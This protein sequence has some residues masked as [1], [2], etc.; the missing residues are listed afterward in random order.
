MKVKYLKEHELGETLI[1]GQSASA[2]GHMRN[3]YYQ[4]PIQFII[5]NIEASVFDL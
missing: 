3:I 2:L 4:P 5:S 1:Q